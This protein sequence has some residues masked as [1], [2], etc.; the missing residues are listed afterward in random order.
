MSASPGRIEE[1]REELVAAV[2]QRNGVSAAEALPYVNAVLV[3]L[4]ESYG[5]Q[6]LYIPAPTAKWDL[7]ILT[8]ALRKERPSQVARRF[9]MSRATAYRLKASLVLRRGVGESPA[10]CP[11]STKSD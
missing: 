4:Q 10:P 3:H 2:V 7:E 8:E 6:E 5:T 9:G 1:L 11:P